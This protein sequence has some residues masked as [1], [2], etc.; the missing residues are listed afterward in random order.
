[1]VIEPIRWPDGQTLAAVLTFDVDG[2]TAHLAEPHNQDRPSL[3]SMGTYG[4]GIGL[5]RLLLLLR[6]HDILATFFVP[7]AIAEMDPTVVERISDGGHAIGHHGYLHK[8]NDQLTKEQEEAELIK[9]IEMLEKTTGK[10][11]IGYRAP[12]WELHERSLSLLKQYGFLYDA[13]LQA[14]DIP[15]EIQTTGGN[16]LE[17]PG[18]WVLDDW[19]QFAFSGDWRSSYHI[20]EP[21]KVYRLWK[22]EFDALYEEGR[23]FHLTMHPQLM[24]RASRVQLLDRLITHMKSKP[25]VWFTTIDEIARRWQAEDLSFPI[26]DQPNRELLFPKGGE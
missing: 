22:A 10:K 24:G 4:R 6:K 11:P 1:M 18:T 5:D 20:E 26:M 2:E 14:N 25:H 7:G 9:G 23:M 19:E 17:V 15:Y 12:L 16:L 13:S 8:P 3:L 21:D